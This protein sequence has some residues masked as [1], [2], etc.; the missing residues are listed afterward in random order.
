MAPVRQLNARMAHVTRPLLVVAAESEATHLPKDLPL[1]LTG[2]GK[3]AAAVAVTRALASM[4]D[5][6]DVLVINLGTAGG[7]RPGVNG[8]L[9]PV[10]VL[11]HDISADAIRALGHDPR[12]FLRLHD[13]DGPVL[14]TGDVFV[15][16]ELVRDQLAQRADLV[17]MEGYA[18]AYACA[19]FGVPVRM[20]KHISDQADEG[21][22]E[23]AT[24]VDNSAR[25]LADGLDDLLGRL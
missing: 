13:G 20:L 10:A 19:E 5:L 9:E 3:T 6:S 4:G 18:V 8:L 12:E 14:A 23:W 11:N 25:I 7:L 1:V 17:D 21:A 2:I 15:A 24:L 22:L 16:D